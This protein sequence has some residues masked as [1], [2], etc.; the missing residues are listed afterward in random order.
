[1]VVLLVK[2]THSHIPLTREPY[3]FIHTYAVV[4]NLL[5]GVHEKN[6]DQSQDTDKLYHVILYRVHLAISGVRTH[7]VRVDRHLLLM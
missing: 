5:I 6:T 7:N 4:G 1:M 3:Q 2:Y